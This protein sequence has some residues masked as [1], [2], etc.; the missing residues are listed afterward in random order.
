MSRPG[1]SLLPALLAMPL[2]LLLVVPVAMLVARATP[3]ALLGELRNRETLSAIRVSLLTSTVALAVIIVLGTPLAYWL[4]RSRGRFAAIAGTLTDLPIVLPPSVA[5]VA[6]LLTLGRAGP[7][8]GW[9]D[10]A[11]VRIAFTPAAVV[12]AQVFVAAPYF[13]RAARAGF[14]SI[15][16]E[17]RE[18]AVIDGASAWELARLVLVPMT[19]RSLGAGAAMS[20]SRAIGE[21]GATIIFAGNLSGVTQTMPMAVY[22]GFENGLERALVLSTVLIGLSLVLLITVRLLG[23]RAAAP[24]S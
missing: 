20:W 2:L 15:G 13:I 18:S 12:I 19:A 8:G 6:L 22:L 5:G 24:A 3:D 1:R 9:L 10:S 17:L 14:E 23:W 16:A 21:F 7:V 11:G 4:S